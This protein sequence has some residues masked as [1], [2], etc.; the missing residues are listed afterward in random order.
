MFKKLSRR[1]GSGVAVTVAAALMLTACGGN[2]GGD[3]GGTP[4]PNEEVTLNFTWWGNED[5]AERYNEAIALFE[6]ANPNIDVN[7]TFMDF[8]AYWEKRQTEAA[9]GGLPD[10]MQFDY[11]YLRQYGQNGLLLD[12][13]EYVGNG[14]TTDTIDETLLATGKLEDQ[15]LAVPTGYNA[16]SLFEN[17]AVIEQAGVEGYEGGTSWDDYDAYMTSVT[18]ASGGEVWGGTDYT[19][20]IQ[21]F[22]LQLRQQGRELFTEEGELN[23]TQEELAEFWS[24]A[25]DLRENATI[26]ARK[27][28]EVNPKS[29]FGAN[30]TA[31]E[32]TWSNFM[33]GY[34]ADTGAEDL[35]ILA[36]PTSDPSVKDLYQKPSMLHAVGAQTEHPEAAVAFIEFLINSPEVGEIFGATLGVPAS[37]TALEGAALE[38]PELEV[39]EY[40]DSV[41]D[42]IGD[43]PAA[44]VVGYGALENTFLT[45]GTSIGLDAISPE[46]AAQQFFDEAAVTLGR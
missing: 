38:G 25:Q 35:T 43:P 10:V 28:E 44:P 30:L 31:S 13:T 41:A 14:L 5:R 4:D 21:N 18:E 11:S 2:G 37:E 15:T 16:W 34:L 17:P 32:M 29:G 9:G 1:A 39:K 12:L 36:P 40:L 3:A 23:F 24:S 26:P 42:R 19:G 22:E 7:G 45:L 8:P 20:R 6:D 46:D 33:G 27:L